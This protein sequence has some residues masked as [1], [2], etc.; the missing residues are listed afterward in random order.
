VGAP[1]VAFVS[2]ARL[3]DLADEPGYLSVAPDLV[4]EVVS[5]S[6]QSSDLEEKVLAWLAA[7]VRTVL[8]VDPQTKTMRRYQSADEVQV[9]KTGSIDL[10]SVIAGLVLDV[11]ELF[12]R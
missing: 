5:P 12:A 7:G 3:G 1:D 9:Y 4:A 8:V 10:S 2:H 11:S 6:D